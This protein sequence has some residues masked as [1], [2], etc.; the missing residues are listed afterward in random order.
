MS[1]LKTLDFWS[2]HHLDE[3][4]VGHWKIGPL[5][6]WLKRYPNEWRIYSKGHQN[7]ALKDIQKIIPFT[8]AIPAHLDVHRFGVNHTCEELYF[9]PVL[10]ERPVVVRPERPFHLP[11]KE[12]VAIFVSNSVWLNVAYG[13]KNSNLVTLPIL[14]PSDTW[15][16]RD[17]MEGELCFSARTKAKIR[18][19][20]LEFFP[21]RAVTKIII[22]NKSKK[23]LFL[24]RVKVPIPY[25]SLYI[26]Q[27]QVFFT[28]T[29]VFTKTDDDSHAIHYEQPP[30]DVAGKCLIIHRPHRIEER[31]L[32]SKALANLLG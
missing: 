12:Q 8:E 5:E 23:D 20:D 9:N 7:Y 31:S 19:S 16:G 18:F 13:K 10:A 26:S 32:V 28:D 29:I 2:Q 22:E 6:L 15:F 25:L 11:A 3:N 1:T 24:E 27:E 30:Q 21:Y 4:M 14:R 17:T